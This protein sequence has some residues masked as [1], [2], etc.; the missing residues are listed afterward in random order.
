MYVCT[1][2]MYQTIVQNSFYGYAAYP[3][4]VNTAGQSSKS[5]VWRHWM[6]TI[7]YLILVRSLR[8]SVAVIVEEVFYMHGDQASP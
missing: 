6:L 8:I 2:Y 1:V 4:P 5:K 3:A 7:L